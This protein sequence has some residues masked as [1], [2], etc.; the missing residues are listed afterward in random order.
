M[1][2]HERREEIGRYN[3]KRG[4]KQGCKMSPTLFNLIINKVISK[5]NSTYYKGEDGE[6]HILY[7]ADD[8]LILANTEEELKEKIEI[9]KVEYKKLGLNIN[10]DK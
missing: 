9:V 3:K 8:C 5:I 10:I 1:Y 4:I 6:I 2:Y 7:Y